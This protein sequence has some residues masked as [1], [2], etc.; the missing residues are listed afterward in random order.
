MKNLQ[1][2]V[3]REDVHH[4][5]NSLWQ[6]DLFRDSH[7]NGGFVHDAVERFAWLPRLFCV[8]SNTNLERSHFSTGWG[9]LTRRSD[10]T[11]PY[12]NDLYYLHEFGHAGRMPYL[13]D[14]GRA[15]FDEKMQRNELEASTLSEIQVYFE[16]PEL[17]S[18]S[19]PFP[20][21]ADRF[22]SDP[23]MRR[24]WKANKGIAIE[25]LRTVRR[26]VML[27]KPEHLMDVTELWIRRFAEQNAIYG[28][29]WADRYNEI[30]RRMWQFQQ[31]AALD[32]GEALATHAAWIEA[33]AARDPV[34]NIPFRREAELFAPF[35]W[36]NKERYAQAMAA[37]KKAA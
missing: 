35:Y 13:A 5:V 30:E 37:E 22:L 6:T 25:T 33:E 23:A 32:R 19:F 14:I 2:V 31:E 17:R 26:D 8:E 1:R 24:L 11:N 18:L 7:A 12:V 29:V 21:Y 27:S 20:I 28:I 3:S 15:A 16:L 9:V 36:A 10:Y 4:Y 34:D